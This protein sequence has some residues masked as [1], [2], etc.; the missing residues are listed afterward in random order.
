VTNA[1]TADIEFSVRR[2]I[3]TARLNRPKALNALTLDMIKAYVP[4]LKAWAQD[5][6]ICCVVV[7]SDGDRAFCAGGDV[8]AVYDSVK[9]APSDLHRTFFAEEYRMIRR[10]HR[11]PKPYIA[12]I[13]GITMG[14]GVGLSRHGSHRIATE[15]T[16]CAMP[17]T[18]IGLFPDIGSSWFLHRCPGS[19]G[20]YLGLTGVRMRSA[21]AMYAGFATH[22][23]PSHRLP[24]VKRGLAEADWS[25]DAARAVDRALAEAIDAAAVAP[26][27]ARRDAIDR[28]FDAESIEQILRNLTNEDSDWA[29][30]T[31]KTLKTKSPTSLKITVEQWRRGKGLSVE[32]AL[33]M[34]Y[35]MTQACMARHDFFEGIRALLI[36]KD[37]RPRW[38]PATLAELSSAAVA[39][40]FERPNHGDLVFD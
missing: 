18:G 1:K 19:V 25:G 38:Q 28:C 23:V 8:R 15:R 40:Y 13:D 37:N 6:A 20:L 26:L 16:L 2:G 39:R 9:S 24:E 10:I 4:T 14:G 12:F 33:I 35:R 22:V 3:A 29:E 30:E 34:E 36:D 32:D 31:S 7:E 17:E 5:P 27:A 21:D 11:F